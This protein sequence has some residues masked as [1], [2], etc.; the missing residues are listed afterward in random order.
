MTVS[1]AY[2]VYL[3]EH[4]FEPDPAQRA[5][6][7]RLQALHDELT[8][9]APGLLRQ[10]FG[11]P[12]KTPRGL[13]IWGGVGRGKTAL[14]DLFHESLPE[15][16]KARFHFHRF[17]QRIHIELDAL[18]ERTDPLDVIAERLA[19]QWQI[20]CFDEFFVSDIAD[21]MLLG[22]LLES[23]FRRG[24]VLVATSNVAP[25]DLYRDGLQRARFLPAIAL[26][27]EH[28]DTWH[29]ET[30]TDY[31]LRAL[32][33][34]ATYKVGHASEC[35]Q[36]LEKMFDDLASGRRLEQSDVAIEGRQ[37]PVIQLSMNTV[38][39]D[40]AALC[41]GPRGTN[42]YI[43]LARRFQT[44]FISHVPIMDNQRD[45]AARRFIAL[46]DEFYDRR[47]K[48]II[49]SAVAAE[50]LYQGK[51]LAFEFE[52]TVSRLTEMHSEEYLAQAHRP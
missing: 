19:A 27:E 22:R 41:E 26:I 11:S 8:M 10:W 39:F 44:V 1:K 45:D 35:N 37:I 34:G 42:D 25:S 51:R 9:P 38:W 33:D 3:S 46:V 31:R 7:E 47:V 28:C 6:V 24:V 30:D 43:E 16:G 20:V 36:L 14:M 32:R 23:L 4:E 12:T 17:M 50:N 40:F 2:Q 48:L 18:A 15:T 49:A 13:Y 21:A 29:L 52:R 5:L